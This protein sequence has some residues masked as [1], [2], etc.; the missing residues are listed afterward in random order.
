MP[1]VKTPH[2]RPLLAMTVAT[3]L[4]TTTTPPAIACGIDDLK[5]M[6]GDWLFE[7]GTT[8][9]EERWVRT[10]ANTL[11][12][13]SWGADKDAPRFAEL[14]SISAVDNAVEM[15]LRHFDGTLNHA[16]EEKDAPM[17]FRLTQC[18]PMRAIFE[19]T[20]AKAGEHITYSRSKDELSFVG[21][22]LRKGQPFRVELR[23]Q[24]ASKQ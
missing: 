23:M 3:L 14:V 22:F 17:V 24:A 1:V 16:W 15:H 10:T 2:R 19:G 20:G 11:A 12:G 8:H 5:F 9:S 4:A 6:E 7:Q 18:E 21:D 13:S